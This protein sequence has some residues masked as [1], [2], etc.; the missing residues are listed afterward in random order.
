MQEPKEKQ[1]HTVLS[2]NKRVTELETQLARIMKAF[3]NETGKSINK[4]E[5]HMGG[6]PETPQS[7]KM[8]MSEEMKIQSMKNAIAILPPNLLDDEGRH[9]IINIGRICGFKPTLDMYDRVY[10]ELKG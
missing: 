6:E 2:L 10:E 8:R 4:T 5:E 3:G 7:R 9:S 1:K